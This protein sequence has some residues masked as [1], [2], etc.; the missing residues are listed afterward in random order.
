MTNVTQLPGT[1]TLNP[2]GAARF[3]NHVIVEGRKIP[4]LAIVKT[5]VGFDLYLDDRYCIEVK[6]GDIT[7]V[8]WM[9]AHA[10]AI[11]AGYMSI[12][13]KKHGVPFAPEVVE[14]NAD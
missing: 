5:D 2:V 13:G 1:Q 10:I 8:T 9:V 12:S 3:G 4:R 6:A 11:G 7:Q 14:I